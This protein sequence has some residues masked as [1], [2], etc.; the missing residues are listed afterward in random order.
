MREA[1]AQSSPSPKYNL[2]VTAPFLFQHR[3]EFLPQ[4]SEDLFLSI[5]SSPG[6]FALHGQDA[7]SQPYL[8]R[9]ADLRRRLRRLLA[10]AESVGVDG[11][12][13]PSRRLN[14]RSRIRG[15]EW[16]PTGS[17]FESNLL[18]YRA[19]R[20][21]FG[22]EAARRRLRLHP[23][24]MLRVTLS[25]RHP[26]VYCTN[27]LNRKAP[28]EFF[29]PFPSRAA[30]ERYGDAVLDLFQLRRC[31]EDLEPY[32]DHPGCVYG[33]M[34]KCLMP[35]KEG[36]P[37]ACTAQ[38]YAQEAERVFAFFATHGASLLGELT[39]RRDAASE[40]MDFEAAAALHK[41]WE[42]TRAVALLADPLVGPIV[43]LR[44]L[45]LQKGAPGQAENAG[46]SSGEASVARS[47]AEAAAFVFADG[48]WRGPEGLTVL[49]ARSTGGQGETTGNALAQSP[50]DLA[51]L[52][53]VP[54]DLSGFGDALAQ[55]CRWYYRSERRRAGEI[56][57]PGPDGS[58]PIRRILNAA[59]R[60]ASGSP[61]AEP[62]NPLAHC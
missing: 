48:Q 42:K 55:L 34:N 19:A 33:E 2:P 61:A 22:E 4:S 28:A 37:S 57:V 46:A 35:C 21:A 3:A 31:S 52:D 36:H 16:T 27:R 39:A 56:F 62:E 30:A 38:Q 59:V 32:P 54:V 7:G 9:A 6:I 53:Q 51:I 25:G 45:V 17:E 41:Q 18:L 5:P 26:R 58:W 12:P 29:G 24:Y 13:A 8:S 15:I 50:F 40:A 20:A 1:E 14:L 10:P 47:T 60:V 11:Q 44:L 43:R 23:P 49:G